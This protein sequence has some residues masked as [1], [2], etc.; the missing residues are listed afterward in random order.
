MFTPA[1]FLTAK[2]WRQP[3]YSSSDEWKQNVVHAYNGI[4]FS[5]KT[6]EIMPDTKIFILF[7]FIFMKCPE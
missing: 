1:L 3:K 2:K 4:L 6:N 7:D 5:Q